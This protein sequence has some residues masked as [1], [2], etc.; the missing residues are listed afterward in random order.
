MEN[1]P[2]QLEYRNSI[3]NM[4]HRKVKEALKGSQFQKSADVALFGSSVTGLSTTASD[5]D[6]VVTGG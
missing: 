3:F 4:V 1:S 2:F 6:I 5:L